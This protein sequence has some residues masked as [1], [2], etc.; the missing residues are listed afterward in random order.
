MLSCFF[1]FSAG[2]N[3][4]EKQI[5]QRDTGAKAA[6]KA[7]RIVKS[8]NGEFVPAISDRS[9]KFRREFYVL[10]VLNFTFYVLN[11]TFY[12]HFSKI[13]IFFNHA[14]FAFTIIAGFHCFNGGF[15][16]KLSKKQFGG[17]KFRQIQISR[18]VHYHH[19]HV[20]FRGGCLP[21]NFFFGVF[22]GKFGGSSKAEAGISTHFRYVEKYWFK[23]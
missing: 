16:N 11:F 7:T 9:E 10:Y 6:A 17:A 22:H 13:Q 5:F 20:G 4:C 3:K 8:S 15:A 23:T 2:K 19:E 1:W 14:Y 18:C 12:V 21:G